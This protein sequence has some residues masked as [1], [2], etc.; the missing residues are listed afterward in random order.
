MAA[1]AVTALAAAAGAVGISWK[2]V[3][4]TLG[5]A[6]ARA[7]TPLWDAQLDASIVI[8]ATRLPQEVWREAA[9]TKAPEPEPATTEA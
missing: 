7:E 5:K 6:L 3:G 8:A 9:A 1:A 4:G 2:G